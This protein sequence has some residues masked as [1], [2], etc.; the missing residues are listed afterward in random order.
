MTGKHGFLDALKEVAFEDEPAPPDKHTPAPAAPAFSSPPF[1]APAFSAPLAAPV[2]GADSPISYALPIDAGV[3]PD[4]DAVYQTLLTKT[5]FEGTPAAATIHKFLD[6]LKAIPDTVMPSNVKFKTAVIQ[7]TAQAGLTEDGILGTFDTLKAKLQQ[8]KDAF[9]GK[10]QQF[11]AR[12]V[13]GRQDQIQKITEQIT[14]LQ[15]ELA[16]LSNELVDAQGKATHAQSQF[17]AAVQRRGSELEQQ[18]ALYAS[19]LKG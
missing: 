16:R 6:P 15:Q 3:V 10:S 2:A 7:A 13:A 11:A 5:D 14:E 17:E 12:E 8:E 9:G 1:S 4:N 19:L 18:R